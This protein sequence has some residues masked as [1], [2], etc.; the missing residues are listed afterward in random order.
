MMRLFLIGVVGFVL[1]GTG[2]VDLKGQGGGSREMAALWGVAH[3]DGTWIAVGE[4]GVI[5]R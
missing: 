5:T 4:Q 3:H 1:G 2:L